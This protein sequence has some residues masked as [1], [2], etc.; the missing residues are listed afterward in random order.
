MDAFARAALLHA[1][2][3]FTS[4]TRLSAL[5][6]GGDDLSVE[7]FLA[8]DAIQAIGVRDVLVVHC[9]R[10]GTLCAPPTQTKKKQQR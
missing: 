3:R 7:A 9:E 8:H 4:G 6:V 1:L 10:N 5:T 2:V